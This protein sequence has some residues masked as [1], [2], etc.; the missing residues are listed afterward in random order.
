LAKRKYRK[1]FLTFFER[2]RVCDSVFFTYRADGVIWFRPPLDK[3]PWDIGIRDLGDASGVKVFFSTPISGMQHVFILTETFT[4]RF[5]PV[6]GEVT[7]YNV[8]K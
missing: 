4:K 7:G 8:N 2:V 1:V 5:D 6:S 3:F